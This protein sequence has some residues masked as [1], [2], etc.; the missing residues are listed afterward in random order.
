M[1]NFLLLEGMGLE[2]G[3]CGEEGQVRVCA[4]VVLSGACPD[5]EE[6]IPGHH[7][8]KCDHVRQQSCRD[9]E[10]RKSIW[11]LIEKVLLE[12]EQKK[13]DGGN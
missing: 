7:G 2:A 13:D 10:D 11:R 8:N 4:M 6:I 9:F 3:V 5:R 1:N 12:L